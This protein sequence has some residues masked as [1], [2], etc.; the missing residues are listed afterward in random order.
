[1]AIIDWTTKNILGIPIIFW[2]TWKKFDHPTMATESC[3]NQ[4]CFQSPIVWQLNLFFFTLQNGGNPNIMKIFHVLVLMDV[5]DMSR[6]MPTWCSTQNG[7]IMAV[8]TT[9]VQDKNVMNRLFFPIGA[10]MIWC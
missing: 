2:P 7:C 8:L 1:M 4:I 9:L 6:Q 5:T 3:G 10:Y